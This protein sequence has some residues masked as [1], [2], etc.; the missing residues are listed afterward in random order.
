LSIDTKDHC[1]ECLIYNHN[2]YENGK[3]KEVEKKKRKRKRKRKKMMK[4]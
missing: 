1:Q 3:E 4:I 2:K